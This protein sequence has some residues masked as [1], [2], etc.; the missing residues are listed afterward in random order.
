MGVLSGAGERGQEEGTQGR[1]G[2]SNTGSEF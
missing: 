1:D 2:C